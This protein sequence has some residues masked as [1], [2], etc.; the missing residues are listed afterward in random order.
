M[1]YMAWHAGVARYS[2]V[3]LRPS[4]QGHPLFSYWR[5]TFTSS[6]AE[7]RAEGGES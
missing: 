7:E 5:M 4:K 2:G 6:S 3:W 1:A